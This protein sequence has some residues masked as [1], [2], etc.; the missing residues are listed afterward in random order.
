MSSSFAASHLS[1]VI[2]ALV[3]SLSQSMFT[4]N[5]TKQNVPV[6]G[7]GRAMVHKTAYFGTV[8]VGFPN[9]QEFTVVFDTGSAHFFIP[10]STCRTETC[11]VHQRYNRSASISAI[12]IDHDGSVVEKNAT[13]RDQVSLAYGTGEVVGE[14]VNDIVCLAPPPAEESSEDVIALALR[15]HCA[16]AR[17]VLAREMTAEP[18]QKFKFDGVLGLGMEALSLNPA[19]NFFGQMSRGMHVTPVFGVFLA[20]SDDEH[21]EISFG[22]HNSQRMASDLQ[23]VPVASPEHGYWQVKIKRVMIGSQ[24][25]G[26]C[27]TGDCRAILDT[28]T[29]LLGVPKD[30][31]HKLH[32]QLA[33]KASN[34]GEG[35]C[36]QVP[37]P[38]LRFE[39]ERDGLEIILEAED[40]SRPAPMSV[41]SKSGGAPTSVCRASLL[42]VEMP[43]L[44]PTIF[45]WGEPVLR[46]YYTAYDAGLKQIGFA[47]SRQ[48]VPVALNTV[49]I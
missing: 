48:P 12:D 17:V 46:R 16:K 3:T 22:G 37:G 20:Q 19:F 38:S 18:F 21:S 24:P 42:P 27:E 14:F 35:D 29:S 15:N 9:T 11:L 10:S 36:R 23:W 7:N 43:A 1:V 31:L 13:E 2:I 49:A 39:L 32:W 45:I 41:A 47:T 33:R 4:V 25:Y 28:G 26:L 34:N 8:H 40:Y 5:L 30:G 6:E 44:G